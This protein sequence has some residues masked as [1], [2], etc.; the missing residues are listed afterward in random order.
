MTGDIEIYY[1]ILGV[2]E[3]ANIEDL[4]RAYRQRAKELHPDKN[5]GLDAHEQFVLLTEAFQY[6]LSLKT[7]KPS[8]Y[9]EDLF[10]TR[11][12]ENREAVREQARQY[13]R[14]RFEEFK[15]TSYYRN[16]QAANTV[17][18]HLYFF[19]SIIVLMCPL[20]G[21]LM[22]G[23]NGLYFGILLT[24]ISAP[25]WAGIF[26]HK[27]DINFKSFSS[28]F[29]L[30]SKTNAFKYSIITIVNIWFF[31]AFTLNTELPL[32]IAIL[33]LVII[34]IIVFTAA[35]FKPPLIKSFPRPAVLLCLV[36][37]IF[38]L[39]FYINFIFSSNP[40]TEEYSF[41]HEMQWYGGFRSP[42][43]LERTTFIYLENDMYSQYPWFR[44]FF[45]YEAM[46]DKSE[47][48]YTFEKGFLGCRVLK[49]YK[50]TK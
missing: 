36:P 3:K 22:N 25:L 44:M 20:W 2:T 43:R 4:K 9:S 24:F 12:A 34:L 31:F 42:A 26:R 46:K 14:M 7:I 27:F 50:F 10:T 17:L 41:I 32:I 29:L 47:I 49:D 6:L 23:L 16:S 15:K 1:Q 48:R 38:N 40:K 8:E 39:F 5:K 35:Y 11:A 30:L 33:A 19:S 13:A 21:Y 37:L 28:S 18:E 45:N